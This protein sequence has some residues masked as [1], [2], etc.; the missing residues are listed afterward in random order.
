MAERMAHGLYPTFIEPADGHPMGLDEES[1]DP[2]EAEI[3]RGAFDG[4]RHDGDA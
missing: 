4:Y 3:G 2:I 1:F